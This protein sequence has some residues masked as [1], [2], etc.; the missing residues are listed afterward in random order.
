MDSNYVLT[1]F[2]Y[3]IHLQANVNPVILV[4]ILVVS[5][6]KKTFVYATKIMEPN[7]RQ[8]IDLVSKHI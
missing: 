6:E 3:L 5:Q 7:Q 1:R 8:Y 4:A 2:K